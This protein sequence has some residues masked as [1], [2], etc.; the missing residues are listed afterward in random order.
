MSVD[1]E[2]FR[3][4]ERWIL[5]ARFLTPE[6]QSAIIKVV[7]NLT[8]MPAAGN[9]L[10]RPTAVFTGASLSAAARNRIVAALVGGP[11]YGGMSLGF[12][13][14]KLISVRVPRWIGVGGLPALCRV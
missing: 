11:L 6:Q 14:G 9:G 5:A 2:S 13:P 8:G 4:C 7:G 10:N 12:D 3:L 1:G